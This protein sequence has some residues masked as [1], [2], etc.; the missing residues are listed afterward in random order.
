MADLDNRIEFLTSSRFD[1]VNNTDC[2][3]RRCAE[4]MKELSQVDHDL[5]A[6]EQN[7][8]DLLGTIATTRE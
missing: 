7:I 3:K 4:L 8:T 5:A 2:L 1:I 6:E